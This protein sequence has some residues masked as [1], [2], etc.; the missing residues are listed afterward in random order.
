MLKKLMFKMCSPDGGAAPATPAA[1]ATPAPAASAAPA[2]PASPIFGQAAPTSGPAADAGGA[3][4]ATPS[5]PDIS[6][7]LGDILKEGTDPTP[8]Q[9]ADDEVFKTPLLGRW[10]NRSEA[11]EAFRRSQFEGQRLSE[12]LKA[13]R[14]A[15][16]REIANRDAALAKLQKELERAKTT[17]PFRKLSQED[18][19]KLAAE[20]PAKAA[21][22]LVNMRLAER[23]EQDAQRRQES[24][25][26]E[27]ERERTALLDSIDRKT[28][29][30]LSD[31]KTWPKY[32]QM[33]PMMRSWVERTSK[34][35][36]SY[37]TG[38]A[39][40]NEVLYFLTLGSVL[41]KA[42]MKGSRAS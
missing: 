19:D 16:Q 9:P 7:M 22:Y 26:Q 34:N 39:E 5:S 14:V 11:E 13:H 33:M 42:M 6:S 31:E 28:T 35:G 40:T 20:S 24:Q 37:L 8:A 2:T 32:R 29:E 30:M 15:A 38:H 36:K 17:T 23:D 25:E 4:P 18:Y 41:H 3:P 21:E 10:K 1:A 12:E 27:L